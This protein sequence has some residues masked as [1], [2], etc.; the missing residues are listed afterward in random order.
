[1]IVT[2]RQK[3]QIMIN[4]RLKK[5]MREYDRIRSLKVAFVVD[6]C[7]RGRDARDEARKSR[8]SSLILSG[9]VLPEHQYLKKTSTSRKAILHRLRKNSTV[10]V[11]TAIQSKTLSM[12]AQYW[13]FNIENLGPKGA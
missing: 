8:N 11:C 5:G 7:H 3:L 2:T 6:E 10:H 12:T 9:T 1:M 4:K 13:G